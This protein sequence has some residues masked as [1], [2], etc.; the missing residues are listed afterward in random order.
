MYN[1]LKILL[2]NMKSLKNQNGFTLTEVLVA[3]AI[4][5]LG[6]LAMAQMQFL[7]LRQNNLSESGTVGTNLLQFV[8]DSDFETARRI[9]LLNS[10][11]YLSAQAGR[12]VENTTQDNYCDGTNTDFIYCTDDCPC[13][14][15][16]VFTDE[17]NL[18]DATTTSCAAIE[19][20]SFAPSSI[21]YHDN[22]TNCLTDANNLNS[23]YIIVRQ[24]TTNLIDNTIPQEIE[25]DI[26][27][28]LKNIKQF[29]NSNWNWN[30]MELSRGLVVHSYVLSAHLNDWSTFLPVASF[31][32][33]QQVF[34]PHI[35]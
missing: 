9:H 32:N 2:N 35:P 6:F 28:S 31:P 1:V 25:Y 13:N 10:R 12:T 29:T 19:P 20:G 14:P 23:E 7:A 22:E 27:Y 17:P 26:T 8:S 15:I 5:A 16:L 33:A 18:D 21:T 34:V 24:V 11:V 3:L 4:M 30:D